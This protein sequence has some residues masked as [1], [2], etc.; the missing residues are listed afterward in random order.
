MSLLF[1]S[2][3]QRYGSS[4]LRRTFFSLLCASGRE[5]KVSAKEA[6]PRPEFRRP[7]GKKPKFDGKRPDGNDIRPYYSE[8]RY[9]PTPARA[10][11]Y[12]AWKQEITPNPRRNP[13]APNLYINGKFH[14]ELGVSFE[15]DGVEINGKT[16]YA[17]GI[18]R[19]YGMDSFGLPVD[20]WCGLIMEELP[21]IR[22]RITQIIHG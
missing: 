4:A 15:P 21:K 14:S 3:G 12:K 17:I 13:D 16:G 9:F 1:S 19:K 18:V 2:T 11:A 10:E 5:E 20:E 22:K 6:L 7:D 8:D